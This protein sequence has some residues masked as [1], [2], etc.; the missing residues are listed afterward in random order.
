[1]KS[2]TEGLVPSFKDE[3]IK[4]LD[5]R[6]IRLNARAKAREFVFKPDGVVSRVCQNQ[7]NDLA[8]IEEYRQSSLRG[9]LKSVHV[10]FKPGNL[11]KL[12]LSQQSFKILQEEIM[13]NGNSTSNNDSTKNAIKFLNDC[14]M[15]DSFC[16]VRVPT[17]SEIGQ[18]GMQYVS[19]IWD[20]VCSIFWEIYEE[21]EEF[22][23][24]DFKDK[25][26]MLAGNLYLAKNQSA[27]RLS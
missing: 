5:G 16:S 3:V 13:N 1:M 6:K 20:L 14:L 15:I 7:L 21:V 10:K 19:K 12:A 4:V 22:Y 11:T 25:T 27:M 8:E 17:E 24:S 9:A 26:M 2:W 18:E 23:Y